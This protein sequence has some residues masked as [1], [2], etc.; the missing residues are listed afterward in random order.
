MKGKKLIMQSS[1]KSSEGRQNQMKKITMGMMIASKRKELGM[2]QLELAEQMGVTDKAVSKWE[3]D[4]SYPDVNTIPKLAE[5]FGM[6]VDEL[7]QIKTES[8]NAEEKASVREIIS[9][10]PRAVCIAM[11][12][13]VAVLSILGEMDTK[14]AV[15]MLGIGVACA[16]I[17]LL[18]KK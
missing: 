13:V 2:T 10:I 7:M 11:G 15:V 12:V 16:G 5:I 1:N 17:S 4:L 18:E 3:R 9:L 14:T 6:S 8:A